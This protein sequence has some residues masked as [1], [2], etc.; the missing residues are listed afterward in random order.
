MGITV[1]A[2]RQRARQAASRVRRRGAACLDAR[3]SPRAAPAGH[4]RRCT[5]IASKPCNFSSPA[6]VARSARRLLRRRRLAASQAHDVHAARATRASHSLPPSQPVDPVTNI[7]LTIFSYA[8]S[9]HLRYFRFIKAL[10][11]RSRLRSKNRRLR[12]RTLFSLP[13]SVI[14]KRVSQAQLAAK[15]ALFFRDRILAMLRITLDTGASLCAAGA[16]AGRSVDWLPCCCQQW[17]TRDDAIT[18][19]S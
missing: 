2:R 15:A 19:S 11:P 9:R 14:Y 8:T 12:G 7:V 1:V 13:T 4:R 18:G 6:P 5:Q 3:G 10:S 16:I 17:C